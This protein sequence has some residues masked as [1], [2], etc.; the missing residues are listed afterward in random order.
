M[1]L[2]PGETRGFR[3]IRGVGRQDGPDDSLVAEAQSLLEVDT[4]RYL[5]A[6]EQLFATVPHPDFTD[7]D[8]EALYWSAFNMMRQQMMPPEGYCGY[9]HY[10]YSREPS[11]G[12][13]HAGQVFHESLTMLTYAH[14]DPAGAMNSQ[15]IYRERQHPDGYIAYRIGPYFEALNPRN[16]QLTTS[17]PWYNYINWNLY[18]MT[19]DREFLEEMY[20][21]GKAFY[22][23]LLRNRDGDG[24]GLYEWGGVGILECV[25]DAQVAVWRE[26]GNPDNFEA[27]GLSSLMVTEAEA[28][29]GMAAE[30]GLGD[31][32]RTWQR[33]ADAVRRRVN[34]HLWDEETG[35]YYHVDKRDNDFSFEN[36]DD[37][38]RQE[39]AG[40][41]PLWAGI[42]DEERADRLVETLLDS[43]KFWRKYGVPSLAADDS[44]YNPQG[45]W[46]GP[47]WVEWNYLIMLGLQQYGYNAEAR[48]LTRR[49]AANMID[50]LKREHTL[51]E[52][53]SPDEAWGGYH[54]TYIWAGM[55]NSM[56]LET[57]TE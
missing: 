40:L 48:E 37:L 55:I 43:S 11:W 2:A 1:V 32:A 24:D 33:Q 18:K 36:P 7:E 39:I 5:Y 45:Y 31:D 21:S 3:L 56:L 54:Q 4:D 14:L 29:A 44:F 47:V 15:R 23:Y 17:A 57:M 38:K 9:N 52:F 12:W 19:G 42:P 51:W 53:Y 20:Q 34:T 22:E 8:L 41:L 16:G 26:V 50:R 30:L 13:G 49:V 46:N 35:F 27:I 28:L 6:N 10:V 25:R